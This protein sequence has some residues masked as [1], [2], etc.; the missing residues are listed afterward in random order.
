MSVPSRLKKKEALEQHIFITYSSTPQTDEL[1]TSAENISL[2]PETPAPVT[3]TFVTPAPVTSAPVTP[4]PVTPDHPLPLVSQVQ[5][6]QPN[7]ELEMTV[8]ILEHYIAFSCGISG[9]R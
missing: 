3:P 4:A 6:E 5:Y 1:F 7:I 9:S 2:H 8:Q